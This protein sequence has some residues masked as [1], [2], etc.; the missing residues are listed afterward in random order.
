MSYCWKRNY[1]ETIMTWRVGTKG[2][3]ARTALED[4][5]S[6]ASLNKNVATQRIF[7]VKL[8]TSIFSQIQQSYWNRQFVWNLPELT[9]N[10]YESSSSSQNSSCSQKFFL[11]FLRLWILSQS[12]HGQ[13]WSINLLLIS[14]TKMPYLTVQYGPQRLRHFRWRIRP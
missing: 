3:V 7:F 9:L 4:A 1:I 2:S 11:S 5:T 13:C 6:W 10:R 14:V 12:S 8:C